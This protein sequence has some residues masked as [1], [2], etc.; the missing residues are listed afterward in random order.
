L[1]PG[2][3]ATLCYDQLRGTFDEEAGGF[4]SSPKFPRPVT[5]TFLSRYNQL[6]PSTGA[7]TMV[8]RT[9]QAMAEGGIHDHVGGGF[10][11]YAVDG[12]WRV[13]HFEKMLYDQAQLLRT[14][15]EAARWTRDEFYENVAGAIAEY[16]LRDLQL[17]GG[18]F[19]S[20]E[21]ADSPRTEH[22][23][24][25]GEGAFY[26]WTLEE[27]SQHLGAESALFAFAYGVEENGNVDH[28][29]QQE[30]T[31]RNILFAAHPPDEIARF[32][33]Q[34]QH[35]VRQRL[36][37]A[38]NKLLAVRIS[39]P[40]PLRDDK[41]LAGWNGLMIGA[42]ARA[43]SLNHG[44][45]YKAAAERA[46]TF[47]F[48]SLYDV[49]SGLL[50]R[51]FRDGEARHEAHL[52]DYAFLAEGLLDLFEA[53]GNPTW[54]EHAID[55]TKAQLDLF[56]D[57]QRGGFFDTSGRDAS[58]LVRTREQYDGAEPAGNSVS[59]MNLLRLHALTGN[60][61]Y[62]DRGKATFN[63]FSPWLEKQPS[64]MPYMVAAGLLLESVPSQVVV[65]GGEGEAAT[66]ALWREVTKR[67]L[68]ATAKILM[69]PDDRKALDRLMP[70]VGQLEPKDGVPTAYV[71]SNYA[72]QLPVTTPE[73]LAAQL[74]ALGGSTSYPAV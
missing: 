62:L 28:D 7:G 66:I 39:R 59:A 19:A 63:A 65:V 33:G 8:L 14:Y 42:L 5:L 48:S 40:R 23:E 69:D 10:H 18:G 72:C 56:W 45:T 21:D 15:V 47:I 71:C 29:P 60:A 2:N 61:A 34:E 22:P 51:R 57:V 24:E 3:A 31:G 37:A 43:S 54:L 6:M 68:P 30:F 53:T 26:V 49:W 67:L 1:D 73:E 44:T 17:P 9:L 46:A 11:R 32:A 36:T 50:K 74:D 27:L 58:V 55:L 52:E 16:V 41:V 13:P 25:S 35:V 12:Q 70:Y 64:I 38:R 4:G 20:A